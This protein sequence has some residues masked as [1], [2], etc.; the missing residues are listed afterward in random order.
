[1][2]NAAE[3]VDEKAITNFYETFKSYGLSSDV[4]IPTYGL[5]E[6]TVLVCSGG[7]NVLKLKKSS[8]DEQIVEV[9]SSSILGEVDVGNYSIPGDTN[10]QVIVGCGYP[11]RGAGMYTY[12]Y[13][14]IYLHTYI[15]ININFCIYIHIIHFCVYICIYIHI[16]KY[17]SVYMDMYT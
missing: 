2:I 1:M 9:L 12:L 10:V 13:I 4:I 17:V 7:K 14:H 5:A 3:P 8:F 16:N 6:H 11:A 15:Y